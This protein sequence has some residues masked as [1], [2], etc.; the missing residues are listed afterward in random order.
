M[1]VTDGQFGNWK[2]IAAAVTAG[3]FYFGWKMPTAEQYVFRTTDCTSNFTS[4]ATGVVSANSYT[5]ESFE[6]IFN[7]DFNNDGMIGPPRSEERRV[8]KESLTEVGNYFL[9]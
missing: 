8:G 3:G 4:Y 2:P 7:Q 1:N 5:L 9:I 6:P